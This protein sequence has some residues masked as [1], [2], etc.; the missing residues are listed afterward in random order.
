MTDNKQSDRGVGLKLSRRKFIIG[1]T[2]AGSIYLAPGWLEAGAQ[3]RNPKR[4]LDY[5]IPKT[6]TDK[7]IILPMTPSCDDGHADSTEPL[8]AGPFYTPE[9]PEK[10]VF[11]EAGMK[12]T[13]LVLIGR[14][15]TTECEPIAG[16][17]LDFWHADADGTYD[18]EGYT[19]RGHQFTDANGVFRLE[20]IKPGGYGN[21]AFRRTPHI[22]A[23][24]QGENTKLLTTQLYFPD[25]VKSNSRDS[26]FRRELLMNLR[27][28]N[29]GT[30]EGRFDFVVKTG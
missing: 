6:V 10:T 5:K 4:L 24:V 23:K 9:T 19:L 2:C 27:A 7:N 18:N 17:V 13:K 15:L 22:H 28:T 20:T 12:G 25:E 8:T 1:I 16:A 30:L 21:F 26:L 29:E 11:V 14:V 3:A